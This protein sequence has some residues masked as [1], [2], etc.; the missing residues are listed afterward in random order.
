MSLRAWVNSQ[1]NSKAKYEPKVGE[2]QGGHM[3]EVMRRGGLFVQSGLDEALRRRWGEVPAFQEV[4]VES[5][6]TQLVLYVRQ[7]DK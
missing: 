1:S 7:L 4:T 5:L 2:R 3:S 6:P